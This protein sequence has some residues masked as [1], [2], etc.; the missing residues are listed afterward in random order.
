MPWATPMARRMT[1]RIM[2]GW[3]WTVT[4]RRRRGI[5]TRGPYLVTSPPQTSQPAAPC[6]SNRTPT[7]KV[8][9]E[10]S[11]APL[12][13]AGQGPW[14]KAR[15]RC[16]LSAARQQ[17]CRPHTLMYDRLMLTTFSLDEMMQRVKRAYLFLL[18]LRIR[19]EKNDNGRDSSAFTAGVWVSFCSFYKK[20]SCFICPRLSC[21]IW[22]QAFNL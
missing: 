14:A 19:K 1:W 6:L 16:L 17:V 7:L 9:L 4:Q 21:I 13:W 15:P 10:V 12:P 11:S 18:F 22:A 20:H 8:H 5:S 2:K 3:R